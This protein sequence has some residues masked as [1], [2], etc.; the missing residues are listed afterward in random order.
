MP[1]TLGIVSSGVE[2]FS[3]LSLS[4]VLW[5]DAAETSTITASSGKV[6]QWNDRSTSAWNF[7]QPLAI[8]QPTTGAST[9]NGRNVL[10]FDGSNDGLSI[11]TTQLGR[12]V[13]GLTIYVVAKWSASPI[14]AR[15]LVRINSANQSQ[16]RVLIGGGFA[17]GKPFAG[18]RT[19]DS[20]SFQRADGATSISTTAF[21]T[22]TAVFDYANT[23]LFLYVG[24]TLDG[25]N[26]SFQTATTTSNTN[27][28]FAAAADNND[29]GS[30][31]SFG[32][33]IAE[34]IIYHSAHSAATRT[35]V[36]DYLNSKWGL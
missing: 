25:S 35:L 22:N 33:S 3:P 18:G 17:S 5:L 16:T 8:K 15:E 1:S 14:A 34:I 31:S 24:S 21:V 9:Q 32:G 26:T 19:L 29:N 30:S 27:S 11:G 12:N 36:W 13:T 2:S 6:S 10:D 7:T 20:N 4:P 28:V 23:D